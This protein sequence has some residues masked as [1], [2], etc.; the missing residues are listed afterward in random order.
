MGQ[1]IQ[2]RLGAE[3]TF[4]PDDVIGSLHLALQFMPADHASSPATI[5][6]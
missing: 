5:D 3:A 2:L 4:E 1:V 6:S